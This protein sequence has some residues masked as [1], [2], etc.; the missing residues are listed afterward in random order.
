MTFPFGFSVEE[1]P[2]EHSP[3][4]RL[5]AVSRDTPSR[6]ADE[7]PQT[8]GR[9]VQQGPTPR[10]QGTEALRANSRLEEDSG[11]QG[12]TGISSGRTCQYHKQ[13]LS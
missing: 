11:N 7:Y 2:E 4:V 6:R 13:L 8:R 3:E 1:G 12:R 5:S 10:L 9:P